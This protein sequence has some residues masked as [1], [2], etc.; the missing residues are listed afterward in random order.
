MG[1]IERNS[2]AILLFQCGTLAMGLWFMQ[3]ALFGGIPMPPETH[4]KAVYIM[5]A[6]LWSSMVIGHSVLVI[7]GVLRD[8]LWA[9][10]LG[11]VVSC[12]TYNAF[13]ILAGDADFGFLLA[14]GAALVF[15]PMSAAIAIGAAFDG[16]MARILKEIEARAKRAHLIDSNG[17]ARA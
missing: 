10:G 11:G 8:R 13:F 17:H 15:A 16:F 1:R 6:E 12:I 7:Y 3:E 5:P 4:G 9:V 2:D 14:T